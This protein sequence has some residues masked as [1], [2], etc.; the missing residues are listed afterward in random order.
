MPKA[1]FRLRNDALDPLAPVKVLAV[2]CHPASPR[3][4]EGMLRAA[5]QSITIPRNNASRELA[6]DIWLRD[7]W[8]EFLAHRRVAVLAGVLVLALTQLRTLNR[9]GESGLLL[10]LAAGIAQQWEQMLDGD[11][12]AAARSEADILATFQ[13]YRSVSHL[14]AALVYGGLKKRPD[15]EPFSAQSLPTFLAY[16]EEIAR[17][18]A[19]VPWEGRPAELELDPEA[20]WTF[21]LP[22]VLRKTARTQMGEAA[23][24][25][26]AARPGTAGAEGYRTESS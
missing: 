23:A 18:A 3:G 11:V 13:A 21:M 10:S 2:M 15:I 25:Q 1:D 24:V 20:L 12:P 14:W 16:G 17:L 5:P 19:G 4:R 7:L 6:S 22:P 26:P 8:D 9:R